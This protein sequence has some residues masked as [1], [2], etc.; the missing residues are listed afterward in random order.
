MTNCLGRERKRKRLQSLFCTFLHFWCFKAF[1]SVERVVGWRKDFRL[2]CMVNYV[3]KRGHLPAL[4]NSN[5]CKTHYD[6]CNRTKSRPEISHPHSSRPIIGIR[7]RFFISY[8]FKWRL[9]WY[10][11]SPFFR[12]YQHHPRDFTRLLPSQ[13]PKTIIFYLL[14]IK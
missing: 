13:S 14:F 5:Y 1:G 10:V 9:M 6:D 4:E 12:L 8:T 3:Q 11:A 7:K 2:S